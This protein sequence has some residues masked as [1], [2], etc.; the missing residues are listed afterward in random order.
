M[1]KK[2][3]LYHKTSFLFYSLKRKSLL[4]KL[5]YSMR[6]IYFWVS[7][8]SNKRK[9]LISA[10]VLYLNLYCWGYNIL[11][12]LMF[13]VKK[14][15]SIFSLWNKIEFDESPLALMA[16]KAVCCGTCIHNVQYTYLTHPIHP[17]IQP[18]TNLPAKT[19]KIKSTF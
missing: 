3:S 9:S 16:I 5:L 8:N 19:S 1:V 13:I 15:L 11:F 14:C 10:H 18:S 12:L 6:A 4:L 7:F 2:C 17:S